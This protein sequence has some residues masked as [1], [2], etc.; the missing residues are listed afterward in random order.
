MLDQAFS[1]LWM[2]IQRDKD[3]TNSIFMALNSRREIPQ[4]QQLLE[5]LEVLGMGIIYHQNIP[6][7]CWN[8]PDPALQT[9]SK[10]RSLEDLGIQAWI[11]ESK[12][13][14]CSFPTPL[15]GRSAVELLDALRDSGNARMGTPQIQ[16]NPCESG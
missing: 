15:D 7:K 8:C 5:S 10:M 14:F 9:S 11:W 4:I 13:L 2:P 1:L 6:W 12:E 3:D 16:G